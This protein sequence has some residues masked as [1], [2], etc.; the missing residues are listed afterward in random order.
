MTR[1]IFFDVVGCSRKEGEGGVAERRGGVAERKGRKLDLSSA[2]DIANFFHA[3]LRVS[4]RQP[5]A[6]GLQSVFNWLI[7]FFDWW[8]KEFEFKV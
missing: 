7:E 5:Y 2:I 3:Y 1:I 8:H 6:K 4:R